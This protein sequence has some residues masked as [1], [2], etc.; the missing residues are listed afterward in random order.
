MVKSFLRLQYIFHV[1][2]TCAWKVLVTN[3]T[4]WIQGKRELNELQNSVQQQDRSPRS[5]T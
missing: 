2:K 3:S 1:N 4:D 5:A